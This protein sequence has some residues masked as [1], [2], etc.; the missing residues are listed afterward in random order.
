MIRRSGLATWKVDIIRG[1][2]GTYTYKW[3]YSSNDISWSTV[4]TS[5]TYSR[6]VNLGDPTFYLRV[7]VNDG[8]A[9]MSDTKT[10]NVAPAP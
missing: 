1:A 3:E 9:T 5:A 8:L 10:I 6:N 7:S 4:G 2:G